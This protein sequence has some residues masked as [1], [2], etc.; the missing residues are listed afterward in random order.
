MAMLCHDVPCA[1]SELTRFIPQRR[2]INKKKREI[3]VTL[4]EKKWGTSI[5]PPVAKMKVDDEEWDDYENPDEPARTVPEV[6]DTVDARGHLPSQQPAYD[7][8]INAEVQLQLGDDMTNAK[9]RKRASGPDGT[10]IGTYDDNP[11]LNSMVHKVEF[12]DGQIKEYSVNMPRI[13]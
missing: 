5:N 10:V 7:K 4:T 1:R 6:E 9:V 3:F 2:K 8:R 11:I 13:C 12:P